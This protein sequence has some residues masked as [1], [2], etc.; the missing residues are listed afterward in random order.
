MKIRRALATAAL[1][2]VVVA[3]RAFA[4]SDSAGVADSEHAARLDAMTEQMQT[5]Q[6][7]LDKLKKIKLSG[8]LQARWET[9]E[10]KSDSVQ[11]TGSGPTVTPANNERFY[12]RRGRLKLTYDSSPLSQMVL[13]F[14]GAT[15]GSNVNFRLLEAYVTLLD[16]WTPQHVHALSIGQMAVPFGYE[17]ERSSSVREL[18][19]RSRVENVLFPGERDRGAKLV[20]RWTPHVETAVGIFNG[21]GIQNADFPTADPDRAKDFVARGRWAQNRFD[22]AASYLAGHQLTPLTGA[23]VVTDKSRIGFDAQAYWE[24]PA[25]GGGSLKGEWYGGDEVNPDSVKALTTTPASPASGKV[26]RAGANPDHFSTR[27]EGWYAM[28]VQNLGDRGQFALRYD[29]FDPNTD[30]AHDQ[31]E[32]WS[33]G[34]SAFYDGYTRITLSYDLPR[35]ER[36]AAGRWYDPNDNLWTLQVQHKY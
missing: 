24:L 10:A 27:A 1:A 8:Y 14:D 12:I 31:F 23:D 6:A 33:A 36:F 21:P 32:R 25:V 34:V 11:V 30:V 7:D 5:L 3:P 28:W 19:E 26:L 15:S 13:Y 22:V 9:G 17:I 2:L 16:R 18:P 4:Q 29:R 20:S 35:T